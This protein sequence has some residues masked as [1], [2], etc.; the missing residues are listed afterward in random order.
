MKKWLRKSRGNYRINSSNPMGWTGG[1]W[2]LTDESLSF[3]SNATNIDTEDVSIPLENIVAIERK[4]N[5]FLSSKLTILTT[6]GS[7]LELHVKQRRQWVSD[8]ET[9]SKELLS[10][11]AS[12]KSSVVNIREIQKP[13]SWRITSIVQMIFIGALIFL[14][15]YT[16][17][18][19]F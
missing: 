4:Y 3:Q 14:T 19:I 16:L 12:E 18:R 5:D 10:D 13:H 7:I 8:L 9:I 1:T 17:L 2:Y 6:D 11:A 15:M